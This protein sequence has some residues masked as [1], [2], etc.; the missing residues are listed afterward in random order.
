MIRFLLSLPHISPSGPHR[1]GA[2]EF[3]REF[4]RHL[5]K[6]QPL[7][8]DQTDPKAVAGFNKLVADQTKLCFRLFGFP[9]L[10]E[11]AVEVAAP[12]PAPKNPDPTPEK[13]PPAQKEP[14][15]APKP[16]HR[17]AKQEALT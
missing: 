1:S 15:A 2:Y 14:E 8:V 6:G 3:N 17:Y 10:L 13:L 11:L 9:P 4:R 16:R 7:L 12:I 5:Y